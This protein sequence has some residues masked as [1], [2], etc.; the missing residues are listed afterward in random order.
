MAE[1]SKALSRVLGFE[2][3]YV[4]DPDDPGG[5]TYDG[6]SRRYHPEWPGWKLLDSTRDKESLR[7]KLQPLVDD[8]YRA[9]FWNHFQGD[10]IRVQAVAD[11]LMDAAVNTGINQ[12]V[13]F[14]QAA[15]NVLNRQGTIYPNLVVDGQIGV[16][17]ISAVAWY[18]A[19]GREKDAAALVKVQNILQGA[20]Y[21]E[22][23][24][25]NEVKEKYARGW[26]S[27]VSI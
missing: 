22:K 24:K 13:E 12:G 2:Q 10:L 25:A 23:M 1:L 19:P 8:F 4:N 18:A 20:Y 26:L 6:I 5:E 27:R 17:T 11:E 14:L 3:G 15:L 16:K 9:E 21:I 7:E